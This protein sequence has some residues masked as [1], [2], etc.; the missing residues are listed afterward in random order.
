MKDRFIKIL[1]IT[2]G[3]L[4]GILI[5]SSFISMSA[6]GEAVPDDVRASHKAIKAELEELKREQESLAKEKQD[7]AIVQQRYDT[8]ENTIEVLKAN[9]RSR[10]YEYNY[11]TGGL[12][13]VVSDL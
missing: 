2:I 8:K 7:V 11:E 3:L 1:Y 5:I 9:M 4:V 12:D 6:A 13:K 10:G